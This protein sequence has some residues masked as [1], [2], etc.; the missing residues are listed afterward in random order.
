MRLQLQ[1]SA[2]RGTAPLE[3]SHVYLRLSMSLQG[4]KRLFMRC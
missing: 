4:A 2:Q 1:R 3:S